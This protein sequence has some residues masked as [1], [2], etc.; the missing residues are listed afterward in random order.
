[1]VIDFGGWS[2]VRMSLVNYGLEDFDS[3][4]DVT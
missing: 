2:V 1:M 3:D 4:P